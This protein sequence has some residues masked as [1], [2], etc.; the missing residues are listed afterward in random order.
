MVGIFS[1]QWL[2][3]VAND[4]NRICWPNLRNTTYLV[5]S[6]SLTFR[7]NHPFNLVKSNGTWNTV[8]SLS[9]SIT[10]SAITTLQTSCPD[11]KINNGVIFVIICNP[12]LTS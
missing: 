12:V 5:S 1:C 9:F 10:Y 2:N 6:F 11:S 8:Y 4:E 7:V 3:A